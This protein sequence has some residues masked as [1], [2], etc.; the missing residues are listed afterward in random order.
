MPHFRHEQRHGAPALPV[1]G[2]DEAGRGALAGPV[3]AAAVIFPG[4]IW[5]AG[6][7]DS[8]KLKPSRREHLAETIRTMAVVAVAHIDVPT[9]DAVN[10]LQATLLAMTRACRS[11]CPL[12]HH[13]LIDG[14]RGPDDLPCPATTVIGGDRDSVSIAAASVIAKVERDAVMRALD[15]RYPDY[16]WIRNKGYG[17]RDH[18]AALNRIGPT[19]H[20]RTSFA[21]VRTALAKSC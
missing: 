13:V 10:I 1:A 16:G 19:S 14:N 20:H 15:C 12:P 21:P 5:P 3:T 9:I 11:L 4:G 18:L 6:L 17:T 7:D 8:K 2:I